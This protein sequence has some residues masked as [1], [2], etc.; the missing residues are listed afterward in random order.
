MKMGNTILGIVAAALTATAVNAGH[1]LSVEGSDQDVSGGSVKATKVMA[2]ADGWLV[3]HRTDDNMKPGPV[4]GHAALKKGENLDV[5]AKL[6]EPVESGQKLML[7]LH[8]EEGGKEKGVFEYTLGS[9]L[10]GPVKEDGKLI[11]AV[12]TAK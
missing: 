11:M 12:I 6:D 5:V 9:K 10:D 8:G 2:Q 3:I 7:M 1:H 4:I